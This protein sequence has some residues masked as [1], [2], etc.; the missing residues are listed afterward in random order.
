[1]KIAVA[2]SGQPRTWRQT[3]GPL[4]CFFAGH[5]VEVFLHS[6][7]ESGPAERT[8]I[9]EA[10]GAR[11][12][13]FEPR[14]GFIEEKRRLAERFPDR[15]A[16]SMFDM[17]HSLARSLEFA[18]EA[19]EGGADYDMVCRSRFDLTFQG[20]L[21]V[22]RP[23][24]GEIAVPAGFEE[25]AGC[26]DQFAV[27]TPPAL[28]AYAGVSDW[29]SK[30]SGLPEGPRLRP[31]VALRCYLENAAGLVV[32]EAPFPVALLREG[33]AG[34]PFEAL[35]DDPMFHAQKHE[36]W[37]AFARAHFPPS[38]IERVSFEHYGR[39]ALELDRN[40]GRWLDRQA[41]AIREALLFAP[42]PRRVEAIDALLEGQEGRPADQ[43]A[44]ER[45]RYLCATL[46]HRM[47]PG[48]PMTPE[49]FLV[50]A[51]SANRLDAER[52]AD[53]ARQDSSRLEAAVRLLVRLPMLAAAF[54]FAPPLEQPTLPAWRLA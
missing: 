37:E 4:K 9:V 12:A 33:Q 32:R 17:F 26:N 20:R 6:W 34:R 27:G 50:H 44:Y 7:D 35:R 3:I 38:L 49:G 5:D 11:S 30:G 1:M 47:A 10:Y 16:L 39:R 48:E 24:P 18:R 14:P 19:H 43:F 40:F 28:W 31:E 2:L 54:D 22:D 53:W 13:S 42:W 45:I 23:P 29:L 8:E 52:C 51:L 46:L 15:P 41:P 21:S 25:D 36:D